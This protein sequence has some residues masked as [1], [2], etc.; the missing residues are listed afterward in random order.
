M[1]D[2][3]NTRERFRGLLIGTAVGDALGLPAEGIS[4]RRA[5][6]MFRG[7]WRHRLLAK[8]GMVSDDTDHTLLVA[9]CLLAHPR[10]ADRFARRL[11]WCL[12]LW[13]LTLPAGIGFA[14]LR[15][16]LQLWVGFPPARS[17]VHSAGNGPAMRVAPLGAFFAGAPEQL[18]DYVGACTRI[19]HTDPRALTGAKAVAYLA[20]WA[21]K[22]GLVERPGL[23]DLLDVMRAA[24]NAEDGEWAETLELLRRAGERGLSVDEFAASLGLEDGVGGYIYHT[25]PVAVYAW[26]THFGD[27]ESTLSATLDCGGDTDTAAA[28]AG[29]L[30]GA[31]L[32]ERAIPRDWAE[33]LV[34]WPRGPNLMREI[35]DRL[36]ASESDGRVDQP[37]RYFWPGL[38]PRNLFFLIVVLAHG[39][40]RL[41]PPY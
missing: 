15:S 13:F 7:R 39:L 33:G 24:G 26:Y 38:L 23:E 4:R 8:H 20:A 40:R 27:F 11:A 22:D 32:G 36:A 10:S 3:P 19:T 16:I 28:I 14:T 18:D 17:G 1:S 2:A 9:Q 34:D 41:A 35:A 31:A 21:I 30:A 29:A 5:R 25:V 12:R 6:K 37:V